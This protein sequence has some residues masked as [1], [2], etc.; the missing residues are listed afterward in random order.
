MVNKL[1]L[2]G[3]IRKEVY[4]VLDVS[5]VIPIFE[6]LRNIGHIPWG[7]VWGWVLLRTMAGVLL[8]AFSHK[9]REVTGA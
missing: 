9:P 1:T 7:I 2:W 6:I 5:V 4:T 8:L 3:R